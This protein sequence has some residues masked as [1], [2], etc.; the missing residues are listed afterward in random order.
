MDGSS[1]VWPAAAMGNCPVCALLLTEHPEKKPQKP[2]ETMID[3]SV[4]ENK[5][6]IVYLK[7]GS[8]FEGFGVHNSYEYSYHEFGIDAECLQICDYLIRDEEIERVELIEALPSIRSTE[9]EMDMLFSVGRSFSEHLKRWEDNELPDK[10]DNNYFEYSAQPT[11]EEYERALNYQRER[12]D[13]FIKLEGDF[14]LTD[15]FGLS[16]GVTLTMQL[17]GDADGWTVNDEIEIKE[18]GYKEFKEMELKHFG[19]VYGEDFTA[20]NADHLYEIFDFRGAYIRDKLVGTYYFYSSNGYTC[21][22]GLIVDEDHRHMHVATTLLKHAISEAAG[23]IVFLHADKDDAPR[24]IYEKLG[25]REVH[26]RYEYLS[27]DINRQQA[28]EEESEDYDDFDE[29]IHSPCLRFQ[30]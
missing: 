18:P 9:E 7:D 22:D 24:K 5:K 29:D 30:R 4:Y 23:N 26:R 16:A 12:G 3:L 27:A 14:P 28:A 13:G 8:T 2:D 11:R 10:Y 1:Y 25:F 6:I 21:V 20:R 19:P 15:D 17:S